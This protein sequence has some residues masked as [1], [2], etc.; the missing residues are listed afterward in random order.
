[1]AVVSR[2]LSGFERSGVGADTICMVVRAAKAGLCR[3]SWAVFGN[4]RRNRALW[5]ADRFGIPRGR[6][7]IPRAV[8]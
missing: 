4:G 6:V 5:L 8:A 2:M 3:R 1:M 7:V